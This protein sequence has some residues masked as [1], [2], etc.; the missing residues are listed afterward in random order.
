MRKRFLRRIAAVGLSA[1][2]A[3]SLLSGTGAVVNVSAEATSTA[4]T[5]SKP[6]PFKELTAE[7]ITEEMGAGW[8]LGNTFDGHTGLTPSETAWQNDKTTQELITA[9]HNAG[10]NSVR[11]P[12]TWGTMILEEEDA[13]TGEITYSIDEAW[14]SRVQDVVDMAISEGMYVVLNMHHDGAMNE[15]G[16]LG[17]VH[18]TEDP[19]D[20]IKN[21]FAG[22]WGAIAER[23]KNYDEHL[24]FESMNEV[25]PSDQSK[26]TIAQGMQRINE[27]NQA[28]ADTVRASGGNN[29]KRW[30]SVPGVYTNIGW[31]TDEKNGFT[32][33]ADETE[34]SDNYFV[35]VH[36]Y[37]NISSQSTALSVAKELSL[38]T[39]HFVSKGIP[40]ILGEYGFGCRIREKDDETTAAEKEAIREY[41]HEAMVQ[42]CKTAGIVSMLWDNNSQAWY[43]GGMSDSFKLFNR[44]TA[45]V[46]YPRI[47]S[48][49]LRGIN[50]NQTEMTV[51]NI[52]LP[53]GTEGVTIVPATDIA[54]SEE[55]VELV[56]GDSEV[57]TSTVSPADSNDPVVWSSDNTAV[58]TVYNGKIV[59]TG[60]GTTVVHAKSD[61]GSVTKDVA[62]TVTADT[63]AVACEA[64][65]CLTPPMEMQEGELFYLNATNDTEGSDAYLTYS[66]SN[67]KVATVNK[68]GKVVAVS[69]GITTIT[70]TASTGYSKSVTVKVKLTQPEN[71]VY[72]GIHAY[73]VGSKYAADEV[74]EHITVEKNG[75]YTLTFDCDKDLSS[76]AKEAGVAGLNDGIGAI[77]IADASG[78]DNFKVC[79]IVYNSINVDGKELT[80]TNTNPKSALKGKVFNTNDPINGFDGSVVSGV[81]VS[82]TEANVIVFDG[83]E[84]PKKISITFTLS[85][86]WFNGAD[87]PVPVETVA[88]TQAPTQQPPAPTAPAPTSETEI[89]VSKNVYTVNEDAKTVT[90]VAPEK[91]N[92]A[93]VTVPA[94]VKKDGTT[95]KVTEIKKNAF[96]NNKKLTQITIGKNVK[97]I[98]ANAFSGCT[99]L[100]KITIKSTKLTSV[101]KNAFKNI[102]KKATIKV[103]KAKLKAYKKLLK[104]KG[105]GKKVKIIK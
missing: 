50:S 55:S 68:L 75:T 79:N 105:Q 5:T 20:P 78:K 47:M 53:T 96:K 70:I 77:Y 100:K 39:E 31:I 72:L 98:G 97:K 52:Y 60:I 8:N 94:T 69:G 54:L 25:K 40:V 93:K 29:E 12:V 90:Y 48:A 45:T 3:V 92:V 76:V 22:M 1:A 43:G 9:V 63:S 66:S 49:I 21:K 58:A 71:G 82:T 44:D 46:K 83:M 36:S 81:S 2:M 62:V 104:G 35:A 16:Y 99:N 18:L 64:I 103:P 7:Q 86:M 42:L 91:K 85:D 67:P 17:W 89:T 27:L 73:F 32:L 74:G 101:G 4:D 56:L 95:Y 38:M 30:L 33:P 87:A 37:P 51:D 61:S 14:L 26:W 41:A 65:S 88:P 23:F 28:F 11:V 102:N 10:F 84:N 59:A 24:I 13:A 80:I 19:F 34:G 6:L 57:V 15:T